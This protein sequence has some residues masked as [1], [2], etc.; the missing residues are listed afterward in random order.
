LQ[1][2]RGLKHK[3]IRLW[4]KLRIGKRATTERLAEAEH[5]REV[6][7]LELSDKDRSIEDIQQQML[8]LQASVDALTAQ[9]KVAETR[10]S[11]S[12]K[13]MAVVESQHSQVSWKLRMGLKNLYLTSC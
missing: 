12:T 10:P 6:A 7:E 13:P 3:L 8:R 5:R 11:A 1:K 4:A 9:M 2:K